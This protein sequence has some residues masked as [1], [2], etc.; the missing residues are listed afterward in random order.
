MMISTPLLLPARRPIAFRWGVELALAVGLGVQ[1]V[2]GAVT[3]GGPLPAEVPAPSEGPVR[4]DLS[5]FER[6][7][8]F[9]RDVGIGDGSAQALDAYGLYGTRSVG[10]RASAIIAGADGV[11]RPVMVGEAV[12]GGLRLEAV[13]DDHVILVSGGGRRRLDFRTGPAAPAAFGGGASPTRLVGASG[14]EGGPA[15]YVSGLRPHKPQGRI[16]GY[17]WRAGVQLD[18]LGAA[19]LHPGDVIVKLNGLEF[20]D[21]ERVQE[22]ADEVA[23]GRAVRIEYVRAGQQRIAVIPSRP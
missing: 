17:V 10:G 5:V 23:L 2:H 20:T 12:D 13:A 14:G 8:G 18:V 16:T 21:S 1:A 15:D 4:R 19:G 3:L 11:Q 9:A 7:N 22:L 6:F